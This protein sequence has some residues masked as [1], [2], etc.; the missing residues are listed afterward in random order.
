M[1]KI[2]EKVLTREL[3]DKE[4]LFPFISG[5][6][7]RE[8]AILRMR[9]EGKTLEEIGDKFGVTKERIRQLEERAHTKIKEMERIV[10]DL[11]AKVGGYV[12]TEDEVEEA[13]LAYRGGDNLAE[14]KIEWQDFNKKL[15][16]QKR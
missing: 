2:I 6:S 4:L 11:G 16:E 15:W 7:Q 1:E 5:L 13:F 10:E 8:K 3:L 12:F 14:Q 9:E